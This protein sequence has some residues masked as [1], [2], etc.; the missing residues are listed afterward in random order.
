MICPLFPFLETTVYV[1]CSY[2]Y[3][4]L[5]ALI[6]VHFI[7]M[8]YDYAQ[9]VVIRSFKHFSDLN[10]KS[11]CSEHVRIMKLTPKDT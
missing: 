2:I 9:N 4:D 6:A 3:G 10:I 5:F 7:A 1:C 8:N 11:Y